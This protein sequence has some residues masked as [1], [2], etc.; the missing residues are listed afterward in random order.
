MQVKKDAKRHQKKG[1][2]MTNK[3]KAT[4]TIDGFK[5]KPSWGEF[6]SFANSTTP[7]H[8][9]EAWLPDGRFA[10]RFYISSRKVT[11]GIV[12]WLFTA[13]FEKNPVAL[14]E[15][16]HLDAIYLGNSKDVEEWV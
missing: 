16:N 4:F 13:A 1:H 14:T 3:L 7:F 9:F 8:Y 10:A 15:R 11:R 6:S 12:H 5:Y 2:S